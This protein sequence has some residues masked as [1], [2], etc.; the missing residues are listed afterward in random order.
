M[1][2]SCCQAVAHHEVY[3]NSTN[4]VFEPFDNAI[5]SPGFYEITATP[6]DVIKFHCPKRRAREYS[7]IYKVSDK[8]KGR[9]NVAQRVG[10]CDGSKHSHIHRHLLKDDEREYHYFIS[11]SN[12]TLEGLQNRRMGLCLNKNMRLAVHREVPKIGGVHVPLADVEVAADRREAYLAEENG[13]LNWKKDVRPEIL[14]DLQ[15]K[16]DKSRQTEPGLI[17]I[18]LKDEMSASSGKS[19]FFAMT[20]AAVALAMH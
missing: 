4:S 16:F 17:S 11:T 2:V 1:L 15:E 3:W 20:M 14:L 18:D 19:L 12:G 9:K 6:H 5:D 8:K 10:T 13:E 7:I